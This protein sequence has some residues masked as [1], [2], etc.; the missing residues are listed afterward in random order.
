VTR[1]EVWS[2]PNL[3]TFARI[4]ATPYL[5]WLLAHQDF[6][7]AFPWMAALSFTDMADGWLARRFG[8]QTRLGA[9]LDPIADKVLAATVFIALGWSGGLPRW[10]VA[11]VLGRDALILAFGAWAL[12]AT[13]I[14]ALPPSVWGKFSTFFQLSLAGT[15]LIRQL[16]PNFWMALLLPVWLW[17]AAALTII[18][19]FDYLLAA[20]RLA[21]PSAPQP[22]TVH[23]NPN[24]SLNRPG[25]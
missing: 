13:S 20:L 11:L 16:W 1:N 7:T 22:G 25:E 14:R 17:G 18:S 4:A 10:I 8:W 23:S 15:A 21:R 24:S 3:L 5:G 6:S 19:G 9:M 2:P 12:A